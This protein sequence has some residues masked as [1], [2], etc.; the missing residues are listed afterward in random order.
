M[1]LRRLKHDRN[2]TGN[3]TGNLTENLTEN[4]TGNSA[5]SEMQ[6]RKLNLPV[7]L[8]LPDRYVPAGVAGIT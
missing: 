2:L 7:P 1:K 5:W 4:L 8:L 6:D 3:L